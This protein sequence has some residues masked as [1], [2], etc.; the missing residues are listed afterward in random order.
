MDCVLCALN[1][2]IMN[3]SRFASRCSRWWGRDKWP[4][5]A[6][7]AARRVTSALRIGCQ[8]HHFIIQLHVCISA[9]PFQGPPDLTQLLGAEG[10][11]PR[12]RAAVPTSE[13]GTAGGE[14]ASPVVLELGKA[15][16]LGGQPGVMGLQ[17]E[18]KQN[19]YEICCRKRPG[20]WQMETTCNTTAELTTPKHTGGIAHGY[21]RMYGNSAETA[22]PQDPFFC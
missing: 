18:L 1:S 8:W 15:T 6:A 11:R 5:E 16:V 22:H 9:S 10:A 7:G 20:D 17:Q 14:Q 19:P 2:E 21:N 12:V 4:E 13:F 3:F